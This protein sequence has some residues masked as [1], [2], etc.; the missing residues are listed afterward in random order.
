MDITSY[1][2]GKKASGGGSGGVDWSAIG[3]NET[4]DG[5]N[6]IYNKAIAVKNDWDGGSSLY[7]TYKNDYAL[8]VMP[9]IDTSNVTSCTECFQGCNNLTDVPLL[10]LSATKRTDKMFWSC[11]SLMNVPQ[12]DLKV[13][14]NVQ[15]MFI[16]CNNLTDKSLDNI[17]K[18]CINMNPNYSGAKTLVE[19]G[20]SSTNYPAE[21]IQALPSYQDFIDAGWTTGY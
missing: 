6:K 8:Y 13:V 16:S 21:K 19:L 9:L 15:S 14:T 20:F 12:F 3:Y 10:D 2:L 7:R 5:I 11:T 17:L 18:M 4:P 1:L